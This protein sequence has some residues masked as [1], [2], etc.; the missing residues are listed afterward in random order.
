MLYGCIHMATVWRQRVISA[1]ADIVVV[2]AGFI[3]QLFNGLADSYVMLRYVTSLMKIISKNIQR[4]FT[5]SSV[6]FWS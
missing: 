4:L 3:F 5:V 2:I 1:N 6:Y